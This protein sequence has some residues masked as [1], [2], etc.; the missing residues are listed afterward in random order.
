MNASNGLICAWILDG[1]GGGRQVGWDEVGHYR[2]SG[3]DW[4]WLH[5]DYSSPQVQEWLH[6]H[7]GLSDLTVEAL[8]QTETRPRVVPADSG[9][10]V[11]LRAVNLN[12][13]AEPDD[14]V[15][16]R[17]WL[18]ERRVITLRHR[19]LVS[20]DDLRMALA[21]GKGPASPGEFLSLFVDGLLD[22][23]DTVV[24]VIYGH[25]D[26]LETADQPT[27][28]P[29][30]RR[31]LA[32]MRRQA[33]A[34]RRFLAPQREALNRLTAEH[35]QILNEQNRLQLR[36]HFDRLTRIVE[37]L[38]AARERAAVAQESLASLMAEQTNQRMFLL[39][40]VAAI[41]LPL[42]FAT[43]LLGI[44]VGGIP[45]TENPLAFT[46]VVAL[47]LVLGVGLWIYFRSRDWF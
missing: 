7:S 8:S 24:E 39:S 43:G 10:M 41:F 21:A 32:E 37:D 26:D 38:D 12:P 42:S 28:I 29:Q 46:T 25:I 44:N 19:R 13:G 5:F 35:T 33:I 3:N 30:Q 4:L 27:S 36:E 23:V 2:P 34:L 15:S 9:L 47:L 11:F 22:R 14:M 20:V 1:E 6:A 31:Q 45:G 16:A 17:L 40:I 18:D